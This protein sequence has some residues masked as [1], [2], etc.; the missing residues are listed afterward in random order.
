MLA[1]LRLVTLA[2]LATG[3]MGCVTPV[4]TTSLVTLKTTKGDITIELDVE[5]AP[6]S[7]AN[8]LTYAKS[9]YYDGLIFHRVINEFM[10]QGGGFSQDA[11]GALKMKTP[12]API[13]NE[14]RNGLKNTL[15]SIAMARRPDPSSATSQFFINHGDNTRLDYPSFDGHGYAVFGRVIDGLDVV[16]AIAAVKTGRQN[17]MGDV[18][19]KP[20]TIKKTVVITP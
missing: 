8:F 7:C 15:G 4:P 13:R 10:I 5:K 14:S 19:I 12:N 20:I 17:G 9:G 2:V 6:I 3:L 11:D 18:P 1:P 16:D